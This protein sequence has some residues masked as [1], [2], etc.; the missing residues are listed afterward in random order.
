MWFEWF[1]AEP[2]VYAPPAVKKTTLYEFR[3]TTGYMMLF[4]PTGFALE[5]PLQ[6]TKTKYWHLARKRK[7]TLSGSSRRMDR[8]R[9]QVVH[10]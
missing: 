1:T 2:R 4:L 8:Q 10:P 9:L 6:L 7:K 3:H 5:A